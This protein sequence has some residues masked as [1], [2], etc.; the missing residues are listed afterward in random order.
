V[1]ASDA[2]ICFCRWERDHNSSDWVRPPRHLWT[3]P[4]SEE[5]HAPV[6][7]SSS[8][9]VEGAFL[10]TALRAALAKQGPAP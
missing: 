9:V 1:S 5:R 10:V 7:T 4:E 8:V 3:T 6:V 2:H